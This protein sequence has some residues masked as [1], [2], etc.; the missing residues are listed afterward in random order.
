MEIMMKFISDA[1]EWKSAQEG[2]QTS[3][4]PS[5]GI[6]GRPCAP[7]APPPPIPPNMTVCNVD[8]AWD[9]LSGNCGI[10]G[11]FSGSSC[12]QLD[13][14]CESRSHVS[15]AL[16][17]EAITIRS[18]VMHAASLNVKS[19]MIMSDS[20]SMVKLVKGKG[21]FPALFG[22]LFDIYHFSLSFD[23]ISFSYVSRL[24]NV[25]ADSVARS[26]LSLLNSSSGHGV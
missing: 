8:A 18:A 2:F 10:G 15:S 21:S 12:L 1:R 19:L 26:A 4:A 13:P 7:R 25:M 14:L 20:L 3:M 9:A 17:A 23:V 24:S 5:S 22:I 11:V 6:P 16:M